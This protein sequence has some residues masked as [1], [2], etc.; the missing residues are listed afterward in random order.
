MGESVRFAGIEAG[1][2]TWVLAIAHGDPT[3]IVERTELPTTTPAEVLDKVVNWLSTRKFDC[4]G[5]ASFGPIDLH[6]ATSDKWGYI[7]TSPK[8]GWQWVDVLGPIARGLK[9][10]SDFPVAFDTD[11]NAPA[12]AEYMAA[13]EEGYEFSSCAYVTVGTGIGVGLTFNGAPLRGM[14]HG[15]GG[16]ISVP[17]LPGDDEIPGCNGSGV[18]AGS[19]WAGVESMCNSAALAKR[20]GCSAHELK[21][22]SDSHPVWDTAAHYLGCLCANMILLASPERIVLSGGV[23]QRKILFDKIRAKTIEY[24]NGYINMPRLKSVKACS[25]LIV[26]SR[27]ENN[28]G[29]I[30]ALYLAKRV[31]DDRIHGIK[32]KQFHKLGESGA[33]AAIPAPRSERHPTSAVIGAFFGG[34]LLGSLLM[35]RRR[36]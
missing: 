29:I 12:F 25:E 6:R 18:G 34:L 9:L 36:L 19:T 10:S 23:L 1:G 32:G 15:E 33:Y 14:L 28:A 3:N 8:P 26:P 11:V 24:L 7:T 35:Y 21:D 22:L 5:V 31:H 4:L 13:R 30:G 17:R 20:A 16:H 27:W 2:T